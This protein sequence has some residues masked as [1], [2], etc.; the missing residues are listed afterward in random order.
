MALPHPYIIHALRRAILVDLQPL[1]KS[2]STYMITSR[3][4]TGPHALPSPRQKFSRIASEICDLVRSWPFALTKIITLR[5]PLHKH[6]I[7]SM[8][9]AYIL[10]VSSYHLGVL[11]LQRRF[12]TRQTF[13]Q[14]DSRGLHTLR[15][16]AEHLCIAKQISDALLQKPVDLTTL[17]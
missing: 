11:Y 4:H 17:Y 12:F 8:R 2:H 16:E 14:P 15:R 10:H 7:N 13:R 5:I 1:G 6:L 9:K 3:V